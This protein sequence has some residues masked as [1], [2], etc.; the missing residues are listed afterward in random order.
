MAIQ[1]KVQSFFMIQKFATAIVKISDITFSRKAGDG[2]Q[3][4]LQKLSP[5]RNYFSQV[6]EP[7]HCIRSAYD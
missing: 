4:V 5:V 7:F 2:G 6:E 3:K 1:M